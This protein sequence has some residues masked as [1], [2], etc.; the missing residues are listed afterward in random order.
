RDGVTFI[1]DSKATNVAATVA[2]LRGLDGPIVLIAGGQGKG[3]DLSPLGSAPSD[4][5][6][7]AVVIG[8]AT[9]QL[10]TV[11]RGRCPV[12]RAGDMAEAVEL[13][14][15]LATPGSTV[16]LSPACASFDM[17]TDYAERGDAFAAAVEE[18][19]E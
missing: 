15:K 3:A 1:N 13:A 7:A 9:E 17:F 2:A 11:L 12:R 8:E 10:E 6:L 4:R 18:I 19:T 5:L 16:L 14:A